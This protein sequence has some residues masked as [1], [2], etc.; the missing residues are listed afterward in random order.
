LLLDFRRVPSCRSLVAIKNNFLFFCCSWQKKS[1]WI[2]KKAAAN[3]ARL[4][5]ISRVLSPRNDFLT[6][7]WRRG[8]G[9]LYLECAGMPF[10]FSSLSQAHAKC[11]MHPRRAIT[12]RRPALRHPPIYFSYFKH[13][14]RFASASSTALQFCVR[15]NLF[16]FLPQCRVTLK[17]IL[18]AECL[19]II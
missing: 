12:S 8:G 5:R 6:C 1:G 18:I 19:Q 7:L 14:L 16:A 13:G 9:I 3:H 17:I 15:L 4:G 2:T 10:Y 11:E